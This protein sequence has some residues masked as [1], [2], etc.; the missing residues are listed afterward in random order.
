MERLFL[1]F[2]KFGFD[3]GAICVDGGVVVIGVAAEDLG[4]WCVKV[5]A[6]GDSFG[7]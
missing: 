4:G 3:A 2:D 5:S 7:T 6:E 1:F